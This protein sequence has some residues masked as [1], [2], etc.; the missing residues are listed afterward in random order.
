[1]GPKILVGLKGK[2]HHKFCFKKNK[3]NTSFKKTHVAIERV[4]IIWKES[5][6]VTTC[7][8]KDKTR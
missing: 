6:V 7:H 2:T 5:E 4:E 3:P 1:M 8:E